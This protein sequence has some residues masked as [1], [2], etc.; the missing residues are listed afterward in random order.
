MPSPL[1]SSPLLSSRLVFFVGG[2]QLVQ[3]SFSGCLRDV[4][5]K[6]TA[7][8]LGEWKPLDWST[9]VE[10]KAAY[11]SWEGCPVASEEG[12]HFLGHGMKARQRIDLSDL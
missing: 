7:S 5:L 2:P 10:K 3:K 8:P 12:A 6:H 1:V 11:E 9:A 4:K